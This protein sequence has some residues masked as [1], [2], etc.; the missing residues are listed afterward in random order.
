M[1]TTIK[2]ILLSCLATFSVFAN[3]IVVNAVGIDGDNADNDTTDSVYSSEVVTNTGVN[4]NQPVVVLEDRLE[5]IK[6]DT[7]LTEEERQRHIE[8]IEYLIEVRD[9]DNGDI[10]M[11]TTSTYRSPY[12]SKILAVPYCKQKFDYWCGPATVEQTYKFL[13]RYGAPPQESIASSLSAAPGKG[14]DLQPML[15]YLNGFLGTT[16]EQ[17]WT[18]PKANDFDK[19][20]E[21]ICE[22]VNKGYPPILWISVSETYGVGRGTQ[23]YGNGVRGNVKLWPY[24]VGGHYLNASGYT[25]YGETMEMTDPWLGWVDGYKADGGKFYVDNQTVYKV[26]N[27]VSV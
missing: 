18:G 27:V 17:Y 5:E 12:S 21:L 8:K 23:D 16:Y 25:Q 20:T 26:T 7:S 10:S 15:N 9:R 4:P 6:N 11:Y 22:Y 19:C 14:C 1:K 13:S 2:T 3:G 24:T